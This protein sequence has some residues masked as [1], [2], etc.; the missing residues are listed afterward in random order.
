[1]LDFR[2]HP[3]ALPLISLMKSALSLVALAAFAPFSYAQ[4][5]G[6][7]KNPPCTEE[8]PD[9]LAWP[10]GIPTPT[11]PGADL[12]IIGDFVKDLIGDAVYTYKGAAVMAIKPACY[13][14]IIPV[15][16]A[17]YGPNQLQNVTGLALLP[18]D[19]TDTGD[20]FFSANDVGLYRWS[21]DTGF[22]A[23]AIETS[24]WINAT[25]LSAVDLD[26]DLLRDDVVGIN[27]AKDRILVVDH[28]ST[29]YTP[30]LPIPIPLG[31]IRDVSAIDWQGDGD[32][33]LAVLA[34][35]GLAVIES[36]GQL[37]KLY[38]LPT[39]AGA[40]T[41]VTLPDAT[42]AVAWVRRVTSSSQANF[43][44]KADQGFSAGPIALDFDLCSGPPITNA[45]P[46]EL[47]ACNYDEVHG[48]DI[49]LALEDGSNTVVVLKGKPNFPYYSTANVTDYDVASLDNP[50]GA[51][52]VGQLDDGPDDLG[53]VDA[54]GGYNVSTGMSFVFAMP[55]Q[56]ITAANILLDK[57]EWGV[58]AT[59]GKRQLHMAFHVPNQYGNYPYI[60]ITL[61]HMTDPTAVYIQNSW[62]KKV[63]LLQDPEV[64]QFIEVLDMEDGTHWSPDQHHYFLEFRFVDYDGEHVTGSSGMFF[65]AFTLRQDPLLEFQ[66]GIDDDF[67]DDMRG[68]LYDERIIVEDTSKLNGVLPDGG[69][70]VGIFVPSVRQGPLNPNGLPTPAS[71]TPGAASQPTPF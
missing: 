34:A 31:T 55:G 42:Q 23:S 41:T 63:H 29:G 25:R 47:E 57:S 35:G 54:N 62:H 38:E 49:A 14:C 28:D 17:S 19:S 59:T 71:L 6:T 64:D 68:V 27:A 69:V 40:I 22:N 2:S 10:A 8:E 70:D 56:Q 13:D 15:Q 45:L 61:W 20:G 67:L 24:N 16:S 32:E 46:F 18:A 51:L 30:E 1:M 21:Y 3:P 60:E 52:A 37:L 43:V 65:A 66:E 33:E 50:Y 12:S 9:V 4:L 26:G 11:G 36:S 39:D 7:P 53:M 58:S 5:G 44:L 48:D